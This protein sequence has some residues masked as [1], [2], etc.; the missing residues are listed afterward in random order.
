MGKIA[1]AGSTQLHT[2]FLSP[3]LVRALPGP[4]LVHCGEPL[5]GLPLVGGL[6]VTESIAVTEWGWGGGGGGVVVVVVGSESVRLSNSLAR[7]ASSF[8]A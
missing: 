7:A 1:K 4:R 5:F 6:Y 8:R 2:P 3:F